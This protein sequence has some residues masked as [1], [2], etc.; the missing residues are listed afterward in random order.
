MT[1]NENCMLDGSRII[2]E[3]SVQAGAEAFIG[4]PITPANWLYHYAEQRFSYF[5]AA[6]DEIATLQ[7]MSGFSAA[8]K[9]PVTATSFPGF[10]LMLE[11]LNMAYMMELPM[12]IVLAQRMG[13]S[14]GSATMGAQGDLLL[15]RGAISGGYPIPVLCP[16]D[17]TDCWN[18]TAEAVKIAIRLRTPVI[19]L[20]SKEM[21]MTNSDF[22]LARL[23][24]IEKAQ[25]KFFE[26]E[27][28]YQP[29]KAGGDMVPPFLSP[30]SKEHRVRLNASTHDSTGNIRK[31]SPEAMANTRR[32]KNKIMKRIAEYTHY[33]LDEDEGAN[34]LIITYGITTEA[35]RDLLRKYRK[36]GIGIS[37]LTLKT[38]LPIPPE[39]FEIADRYEHIIFAEENISG[40]MREIMY[41]QAERENIRGV[42]VIGRMI[43][44]ADIE[45]EVE[46]CR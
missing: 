24:E 17:F 22:D 28:D 5:K 6:P 21:M 34:I 3:A 46:K 14:T 2:I 41:G 25:W 27:G 38:L 4:Y 12:L 44:S 43:T 35:A 31:G 15:L 9:F 42:N 36:Q 39:I 40:Q 45:R 7:W 33:D 26:G 8:G 16:S 19:L 32:L 30:G 29:Y 10:S 18:L 11:S 23:K 13:P 1:G 37:C 20:T